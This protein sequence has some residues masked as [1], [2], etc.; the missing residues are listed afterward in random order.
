MGN[1]GRLLV[2]RSH[3]DFG[4]GSCYARLGDCKSAVLATVAETAQL[5]TRG[6]FLDGVRELNRQVTEN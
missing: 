1:A 4:C 2:S 3:A 5:R 6:F